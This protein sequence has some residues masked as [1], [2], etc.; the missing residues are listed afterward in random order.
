MGAWLHDIKRTDEPRCGCRAIQNAAHLTES[1]APDRE[2]VR[3]GQKAEVGRDLDGQ[4][5]LCE[6]DRVPLGGGQEEGGM[7]T[8][9]KG[10]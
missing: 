1:G 6:G 2:R 7:V 10:G 4:S 9:G 5:I 3:E 8:G